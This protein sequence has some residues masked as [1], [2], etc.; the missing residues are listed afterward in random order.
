MN[1]LY[2]ALRLKCRGGMLRYSYYELLY[3]VN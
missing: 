1:G 3:L 2:A